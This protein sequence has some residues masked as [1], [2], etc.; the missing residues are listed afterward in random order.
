MPHSFPLPY[1]KG[2][3]PLR[4]CLDQGRDIVWIVLPVGI[5]RYRPVRERKSCGKPCKQGSSLALILLMAYHCD[6]RKG[7]EHRGGGVCRTIIYHN[8]RQPELEAFLDDSPHLR[9]MVIGGND[10][11]IATR[12]GHEMRNPGS[13]VFI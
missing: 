9:P 11:G 7:S 8:H 13:K 6:A 5:N 1:H 2:P 10:N 4:D 12:Y 3:L